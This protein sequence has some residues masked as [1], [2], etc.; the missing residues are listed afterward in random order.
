MSQSLDTQ[1]AFVLHLRVEGRSREVPLAALDLSPEST[2]AQIKQA[3]A[4]YLNRP[5]AD[6]SDYVVV[7]HKAAIVVR[8][9]AVYG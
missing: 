1:A 7:R 5:V 8:P 3:A 2:D 9:E 6:L 4:G